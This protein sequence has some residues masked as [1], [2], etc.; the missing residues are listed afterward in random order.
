[1]RL[2]NV[3][4]IIMVIVLLG[5]ISIFAQQKNNSVIRS[6]GVELA[7][8]PAVILN[9]MKITLGQAIR[10]AIERNYD[11]LAGSYE[12]AMTDSNYRKFLDTYYFSFMA[13]GAVKYEKYPPD[14]YIQAG[15]TLTQVNTNLTL[16]KRFKSGTTLSATMYH[17]HAQKKFDPIV[18]PVVGSSGFLYIPTLQDP[19]YH[20]P[21]LYLILE[22]ELLKNAF[23]SNWRRMEKILKNGEKIQRETTLHMLSLV[24]VKV[25]T[26][27]W[28]VIVNQS[29]MENAELLV[30]ETK[31]VRNITAANVR[32]GMADRF[33][34]NYY[35][36]LVASSEANLEQ[37]R[38]EYRNSLRNFLTTIN[39]DPDTTV[40]GTAVLSNR[41]RDVSV[42][43]SLKSAYR[44]RADYRSA[45]LTMENAKLNLKIRKN[46]ALPSLSLGLTVAPFSQ[47]DDFGRAYADVA[48][49]KYPSIEGR[50]KLTYPIGSNSQ[51]VDERNARFQLKQAEL[52]LQKTEREV[53]DDIIS[54]VEQIETSYR[55]YRKAREARKQSELFYRGMIANLRRGRLSAATVKNGVDA[56]VQS[57][58][59]ELGA[60]VQYNVS[61]LMLD[62]ARNE[63]FEKYNIDVD[64]YIPKDTE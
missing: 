59:G 35:N 24:V 64:N 20:Q 37:A 17:E 60:L 43:E 41:L 31:K 21:A 40:S 52:Q 4:S 27:Y 42:E 11:I 54:K 18:A 2:R 9:G 55:L 61:L 33:N 29:Q 38:Q 12:L 63:L 22:Q 5:Q 30:Q 47:R 50:I 10:Q 28:T 49:V 48:S 32:Y 46:K 8:E 3:I 62:V 26:D 23:G 6:L 16:A 14:L 34:L 36:T 53:K 44:N 56:L 57:R 15:K 7:D 19:F 45:K 39:M 58:M 51:K 25:I 13:E 1:M